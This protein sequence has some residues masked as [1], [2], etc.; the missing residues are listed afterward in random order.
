[1]NRKN[2]QQHHPRGKCRWL[3]EMTNEREQ[4][5]ACLGY[6]EGEKQELSYDPWGRL[7]NPATH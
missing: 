5:Q 7:R 3:F 6:A 4:S 2:K 1:M